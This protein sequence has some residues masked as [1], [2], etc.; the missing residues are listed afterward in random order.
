MSP[1]PLPPWLSRK[2]LC[3]SFGEASPKRAWFVR[4]KAGVLTALMITQALPAAGL[5]FNAPSGWTAR[6]PSSA[7][8]VAEFVLPRATGDQED[9]E[10]VVYF[11]GGSGGGID[12]NIERWIGQMQQPD[13]RPSREVSERSDRVVN[14]LSVTMLDISGTYT[15]EVRPGSTER[16]NRPGFRM[17]TA[18]VTT[19]RGPYFVKAVGPANTMERWVAAFDAFIGSVRFEQ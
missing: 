2:F 8:R 17:R 16:H 10:L 11:F 18:V 6:Q 12:A 5:R 9:A 1:L 7:M 4:G 3:D 15:A 19:P 14:G 13:G